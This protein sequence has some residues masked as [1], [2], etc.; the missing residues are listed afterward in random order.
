MNNWGCSW[1]TM[2]FLPTIIMISSIRATCFASLGKKSESESESERES[3]S[4]SE[5][6][7]LWLRP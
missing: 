3:E 4:E 1:A 7:R 6:I 2:G 5:R